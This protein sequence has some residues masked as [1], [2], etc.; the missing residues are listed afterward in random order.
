MLQQWV[1]FESQPSRMLDE[2]N[3][4]RRAPAKSPALIKAI[5]GINMTFLV[6]R[7]VPARCTQADRLCDSRHIAGAHGQA[8]MLRKIE[9]AEAELRCARA[10]LHASREA[11]LSPAQTMGTRWRH[12]LVGPLVPPETF[13]YTTLRA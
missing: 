2:V 1:V 4:E 8:P 11:P 9:K 13:G 3:V 10:V 12:G 6:F 7:T 5:K